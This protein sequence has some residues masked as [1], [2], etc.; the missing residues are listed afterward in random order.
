MN[1]A[2]A[3]AGDLNRLMHQ[4]LLLVNLVTPAAGALRIGWSGF[5]HMVGKEDDLEGVV[6][7]VFLGMGFVYGS[8]IFVAIFRLLIKA[9]LAVVKP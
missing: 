3:A 6:R 4:A 5:W 7:K 2:N 8:E 9:G 1:E